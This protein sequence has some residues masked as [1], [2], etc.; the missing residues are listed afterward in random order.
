MVV[1]LGYT[2]ISTHILSDPY[3][4]WILNKNIIPINSFINYYEQAIIIIG[5]KA[6]LRQKYILWRG[7]GVGTGMFPNLIC[8]IYIT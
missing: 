4:K 1:F 3:Y 7:W 2:F 8:P 5:I 6:W